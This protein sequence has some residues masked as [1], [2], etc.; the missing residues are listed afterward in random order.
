M[1]GAFV[2]HGLDWNS[3]AGTRQHA[4]QRVLPLFTTHSVSKDVV[5]PRVNVASWACGPLYV[6]AE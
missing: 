6:A 4:L 2:A 5:S 1:H 3:R